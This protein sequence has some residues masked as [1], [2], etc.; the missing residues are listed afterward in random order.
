MG[1]WSMTNRIIFGEYYGGNS[2]NK[3]GGAQQGGLYWAFK[4]AVVDALSLGKSARKRWKH[5]FGVK[6]KSKKWALHVSKLPNNTSIFIEDCPPP[7]LDEAM[8]LVIHALS[9]DQKEF[10]IETREGW[11][12]RSPG[13]VLNSSVR[14]ALYGPGG[15]CIDPDDLYQLFKRF[16][17]RTAI[18]RPLMGP[19]S[20]MVFVFL[21]VGDFLWESQPD[22]SIDDWEI[23][24]PLQNGIEPQ[25]TKVTPEKRRAA[26]SI[27]L[28]P[29]EPMS[30]LLADVEGF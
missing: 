7:N 19:R 3:V 15:V 29:I 12:N 1:W 11:V 21:R 17:D 25:S 13:W 10:R 20:R 8:A 16:W 6:R 28:P 5:G 26:S 4:T 14:C 24:P 22:E 9:H 30:L 18:S 23:L 27:P 2:T